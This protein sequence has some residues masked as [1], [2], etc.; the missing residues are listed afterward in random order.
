MSKFYFDT[1]PKEENLI[2]FDNIEDK[3]KLLK[4]FKLVTDRQKNDKQFL[5]KGYLST[6]FNNC[7]VIGVYTKEGY[8]TKLFDK[9]YDKDTTLYN[10]ISEFYDVINQIKEKSNILYENEDYFIY[11]KKNDRE[12][13]KYKHIKLLIHIEDL[14]KYLYISPVYLKQMQ[15]DSFDKYKYALSIND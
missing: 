2:L 6:D 5:Y 4:E 11:S 13:N 12:S 9:T 8:Y 15:K 1:I 14:N 3:L 10:D 7:D